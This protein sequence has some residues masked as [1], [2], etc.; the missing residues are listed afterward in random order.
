MF[1][2]RNQQWL[3][4]FPYPCKEMLICKLIGNIARQRYASFIA[5]LC[6]LCVC[7][8]QRVYVPFF[9]SIYFKGSLFQVMFGES[10]HLPASNLDQIKGKWQA[11]VAT[12]SSYVT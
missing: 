1:P 5:I 6:S 8:C 12:A 9:S 4:Y 2:A 11:L 7:V 3:L 10:H